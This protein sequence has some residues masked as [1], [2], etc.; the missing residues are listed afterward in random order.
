MEFKIK[1]LTEKIQKLTAD[2]RKALDKAD[3]ENRG[4]T[5]DE[6]QKYSKMESDLDDFITERSRLQRLVNTRGMNTNERLGHMLGRQQRSTQNHYKDTEE[7]RAVGNYF[8][9]GYSARTLQKDN[10]AKGGF[11]VLAETLSNQILHDMDNMVFVRQFANIFEVNQ[12]DGVG[13]PIMD[14]DM[15]DI[16][17]T[18]EITESSLDTSM[19][20]EKAALSPRRL[21]KAIKVSKNLLNL[22]TPDV[23][24]FIIQRG[25]YKLAIAEENAFLNGNG[26]GSN[27]PLGIFTT[28]DQGVTADRNVSEGN[29]NTAITADGLLNCC[30]NLKAQYLQDP[31]TR[32]IFSREAIK[33]IRKLKDGNGQFLWVAGI[34]TQE[35][36]TINGIPYI[37]SEYCPSTFTSGLRVGALC[38]LRFYGIAQ[39]PKIGVQTLLEK[40]ALENCNAYIFQE[41]V[42]GA[43]LIPEAF[44]MVTLG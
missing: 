42:D 34:G 20:F 28:H 17:F 8:L 40:Y 18:G 15:D 33:R 9:T 11:L 26:S 41:H 39:Y 38:C 35:P 25:T 1:Q 32:W 16:S 14:Q 3:G 10:D 5:K 29:T 36:P 44:S 13:I 12:A 43:P 23:A 30:F 27:V 21:V 7:L 24:N 31:T 2:M 19:N 37:M 22:S 6:E 4:L